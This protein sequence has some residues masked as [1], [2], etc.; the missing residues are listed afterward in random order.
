VVVYNAMRYKLFFLRI[1]AV[2][3]LAF[4]LIS[5]DAA[6]D[7][8]D[9]VRLEM[10]STLATGHSLCPTGVDP[11]VREFI[12][13]FDGAGG[14]SASHFVF[15]F[16]SPRTGLTGEDFLKPGYDDFP[17]G[18]HP[19]FYD[20]NGDF[21]LKP[22]SWT[23]E[24]Y[25]FYRKFRVLEKKSGG[26]AVLIDALN[27]ASSR[28]KD[29]VAKRVLYYP[30]NASALAANCA[31]K[32]RK[33][34]L[35]AGRPLAISSVGFSLGGYASVLFNRFLAW[36]GVR[37]KNVLTLDP[38]PFTPEI[39]RAILFPQNRT[40]ISVPDNHDS[41]VNLYQR[42]DR[43]TLL[44]KLGGFPILGAQIRGIAVINQVLSDPGDGIYSHMSVPSS[45]A[46]LTEMFRL[47]SD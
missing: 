10:E 21:V 23:P 19:E 7:P 2:L 29:P 25:A 6:A 30:W 12:F 42:K 37:L 18:Y 44:P 43:G 4:G 41:W 14:Y 11:S 16:R 39:Y 5:F 15:F 38:V 22:P 8:A 24:R 45:E 47:L 32:V 33:R 1:S 36:Q 26:N 17:V 13:A 27:I 40:L 31:T 20:S 34:Y 3:S 28:L 35:Q 46:A 9:A